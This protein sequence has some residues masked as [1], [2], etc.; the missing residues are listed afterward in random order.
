VIAA[1][2]IQQMVDRLMTLPAGSRIVLLAPVI[3]GR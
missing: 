3:G 1:Q 2:T